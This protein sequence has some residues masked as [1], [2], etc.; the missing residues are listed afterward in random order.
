MLP[1]PVFR[2]EFQG[3]RRGFLPGRMR[4]FGAALNRGSEAVER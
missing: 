2:G 4:F 1:L 3:N